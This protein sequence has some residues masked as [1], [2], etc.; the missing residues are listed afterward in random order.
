MSTSV[1]TRIVKIGNSQGVR[2]PKLL[3]EQT[4]LGEEVELELL[5]D[6]IVIRAVDKARKGWSDAFKD[7]AERGEDRLLEGGTLVPNA[8]DGEDWV[9]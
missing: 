9:W 8:W 6:R 4:S 3:L 5:Q 7:M 2:I 1:R